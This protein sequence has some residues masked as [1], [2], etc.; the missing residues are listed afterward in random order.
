MTH[1]EALLWCL[2]DTKTHEAYYRSSGEDIGPALARFR[3]WCEDN[4]IGRP[5]DVTDEAAA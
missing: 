3:L 5:D 1:Q 4:L 2:T